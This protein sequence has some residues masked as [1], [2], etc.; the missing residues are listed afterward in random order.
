[1][2]KDV[3]DVVIV[4]GG[5]AGAIAAKKL[6]DAK[7]S[8]LLIEKKTLPRHKICSGLISKEAQNILKKEGIPIP[9]AICVRP[10]LDKGVKIQKTINSEFFKV[11]DRFYNVFRR[12]FDYWLVLKASEAGAEVWSNTE[13]LNFTKE[14]EK[15][16]IEMRTADEITNERQIVKIKTDYLIGADG[17][18]SIVRKVLFPDFKYDISAIYQEY[19]NGTCDLDPRYFHAFLD[20]SLSDGYAWLNQKDGQIIIGVGA[21]KGKD[22]KKFQAKFIEYLEEGYGLRLEERIRSE[23]CMEPNILD[24]GFRPGFKLGKE[25]VLLV[26]EAAGLMN[27]F[28][29]GIP[30]ALKSGKVAADSI[31][32]HSDSSKPV[33][34]IYLNRISKLKEKL[35]KNWENFDQFLSSFS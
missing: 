2:S 23:G 21:I 33:F 34:E 27:L 15:L 8:V 31:I 29:E 12:D 6:A 16:V 19:Y 14:G 1:M 3:F 4:G 11:P 20:K 26:G 28:G 22:I 35:V 9:K 7:K 24:M 17:G 18:A 30:S 10:R 32:S 13:F 5:P 25:N